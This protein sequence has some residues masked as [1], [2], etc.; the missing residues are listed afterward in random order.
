M[1]YLNAAGLA[2]PFLQNRSIDYRRCGAVH[3]P[4]GRDGLVTP[5][6]QIHLINRRSPRC[7]ATQRLATVVAAWPA[8][9]PSA[10]LT[11]V[12]SWALSRCRWPVL[13]NSGYAPSARSCSCADPAGH[14]AGQT[15]GW[16][17]A[18]RLH[19]LREEL[20]I[21]AV[22]WSLSW[23]RRYT[24]RRGDSVG[25]RAQAAASMRNQT[26]RA[27]SLRTALTLRPV[28]GTPASECSAAWRK[29]PRRCVAGDFVDHP[30]VFLQ[31][32]RSAARSCYPA[33]RVAGGGHDAVDPV[34]M[35]SRA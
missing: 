8:E 18:R 25:R 21:P 4:I 11:L 10:V 16:R 5:P 14:R 34:P 23:S 20:L 13:A 7:G 33:H 12:T 22:S 6:G 1:D 35:L 9:S 32:I 3:P 31:A 29:S 28:P 17:P 26:S 30:T 19:G 24:G 27:S 15:C 2:L